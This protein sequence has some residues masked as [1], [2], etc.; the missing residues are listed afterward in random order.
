MVNLYKPVRVIIADDHEVT[1]DGFQVMM[2]KQ[3]E[4]DIVGE[5]KNGKQLINLAGRLQPDIIIMDILMP[6][7]NGIEATK[8]ITKQFPAIGIIA[9]SFSGEE[10]LV[11]DMLKAGAKGYLL[12]SAGREEM[13]SAIKTVNKGQPYYCRETEQILSGIRA[14]N[15]EAK[16]NFSDTEML[17]LKFICQ[18]LSSQEIGQRINLSRRTIE[19]YREKLMEKT[20]ARNTAGI[21][22]YA[23]KNKIFEF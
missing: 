6:E 22:L 19:G 5:A 23:V 7:T 9:F 10:E 21:V 20:K 12:K 15:K 11:V 3:T 14:K 4:I 2:K 1:R 18:E 13:I 16:V 8:L 17:I